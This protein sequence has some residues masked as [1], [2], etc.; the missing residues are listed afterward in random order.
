MHVETFSRRLWT[1]WG[2]V[3]HAARR[4]LRSHGMRAIRPV[5][6]ILLTA[7]PA[8][9]E[10]YLASSDQAPET[11]RALALDKYQRLLVL[12]PHCDD[13]VLGAGGLIQAALRQ[14]L[15]AHVI[16][17]TAGDGYRRAAWY[18]VRLGEGPLD[19]LVSLPIWRIIAPDG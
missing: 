2:N 16:I 7:S 9:Y 17:A 14:G 18:L 13:K 3:H 11:Y 10:G 1:A 19:E 6:A 5:L 8:V 4:V 12:A 15:D